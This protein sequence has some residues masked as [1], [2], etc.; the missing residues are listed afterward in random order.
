[1]F[2][3]PLFRLFELEPESKIIFGF[4]KDADLSDNEDLKNNRRFT[5]HAQYFIQMIDKALGLL[6]PDLELLT[7]IL[8]SELAAAVGRGSLVFYY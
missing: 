8:V 5:K 6:G 4:P 2:L 7:D 1:M 3:S